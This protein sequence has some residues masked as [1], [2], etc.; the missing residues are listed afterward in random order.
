MNNFIEPSVPEFI[1]D[2]KRFGLDKALDMRKMWNEMRMSPTD[3]S[4]FSSYVMH[5][6]LNGKDKDQPWTGLF[7]KGKKLKLHFINS[8]SNTFYDVR[9]P[10]LKIKIIESDGL[11]VE[12]VSI[13]EFRFGSGETYT[14]I[15]EPKDDAYVIFAQSIERSSYALGY[16]AVKEGLRAEVPTLDAPQWLSHLD[17]GHGSHGD[18]S[19]HSTSKVRHAST[20]FGPSVDMRVDNPRL[21]LDDPGVGLRNNGRKVLTLADL[22]TLNISPDLR[23][24]S[25]EIELHLTGNMERYLWSIDGMD[26]G[27]A[28]PIHFPYRSKVRITLHN[29]TMMTHP[30]HLHGMWS[31]IL[32]PEGKFQVR[33]HT[34]PVQP[35]QR[36]TFDVNA[37]AIGRWAWHC[38]LLFHMDAGM[39]REVIVA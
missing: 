38:H 9:I 22:H 26:F 29:D 16:L 39:F 37:D 2:I 19:A 6:H 10:G 32:N 24:P 25:K 3:L 33:R 36:I 28:T 34:F 23:T 18:H 17:M 14:A 15:I 31:D 5:Y 21:N 27:K 1:R 35:A 4:D 11:A 13:D 30:M 12:P 7:K 20:E 8:S